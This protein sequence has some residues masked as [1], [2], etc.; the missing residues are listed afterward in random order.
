MAK[1]AAALQQALRARDLDGSAGHA[2][3]RPLAAGNG[4]SVRD[5]IC[6]SG[7]HDRPFE[8]Q[9][10]DVAIA[11]VIAGTFQY[12]ASSRRDLLTPGAMLLG[13]SGQSYEC[14]HDHGNGDRCISFNYT[15]ACF[16]RILGSVPRFRTTRLPPLRAS[17][18][19]IARACAAMAGETFVWW[20]AL[21]IEMAVEAMRLAND[22]DTSASRAFSPN[23]IARVTQAIRAIEHGE[24]EMLPLS[25]LASSAGLSPYHFL[26][27][28]AQITGVTPHQFAL[29]IRLRDA[30]LRLA[31]DDARIIDVAFDSGFG[32]VSNFNR[33]FRAEFGLAPRQYRRAAQGHANV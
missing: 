15:P 33:T 4:W 12:K 31:L 8:E 11:V 10:D 2:I 13:N 32:D 1:I 28:F 26:R 23:A 18:A 6:T 9:H 21:A 16:E 3:A 19:L 25:D 27:T 7:P 14:A 24:E 17:A 30:A 29:R 22:L 5:M 20:E